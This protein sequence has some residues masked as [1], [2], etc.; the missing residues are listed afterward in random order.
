MNDSANILI[1]NQ[2][3]IKTVFCSKL[4]VLHA[5]SKLGW[6]MKIFKDIFTFFRHKVLQ[7]RGRQTPGR[8]QVRP[9]GGQWC[10]APP[11]HV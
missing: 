8:G 11:F 6:D 9:A 2:L 4:A 7:P 5:T 1:G 3:K 10:P